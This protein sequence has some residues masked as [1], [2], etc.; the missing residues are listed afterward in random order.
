M[1]DDA[2]FDD[3]A[4]FRLKAIGFGGRNVAILAQNEN[5][6]CPLLAIANV[7]LL[8][9]SIEIHPDRPQVSYEELVEL[10]GD[11]LFTSNQRN[12]ADA[13]SEVSANAAH[14]LS[15]CVAM[16]PKLKRGLDINVRFTG[17]AAAP[18]ARL[19]ATP[20]PRSPP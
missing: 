12:A 3:N 9:G 8:R 4:F 5:G 18:R 2:F 1:A 6:P 15:D 10:V 17:C 16:F 19:C 11:Y 7:L 20:L 13:A 14:N